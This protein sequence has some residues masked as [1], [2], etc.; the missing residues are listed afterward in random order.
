MSFAGAV[1]AAGPYSIS[2][3]GVALG[4]LRGDQ[5]MPLIEPVRRVQL[6]TG[7]HQFAAT[8]IGAVGLGGDAFA[9]FVL[10]E[11]RIAALLALWPY[12]ALGKVPTI[13]VDDYDLAHA[14]VF[15]ALAGTLAAAAGPASITASKAILREDSPLRR[16]FGP[17][18]RETPVSMRLFPDNASSMSHFTQV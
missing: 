17:M 1:F 16:T 4:L 9:Q 10:M 15:T 2:H 13:S 6:I 7:T 8:T 11:S 12:S 18:L 14:L 3:N 5:S